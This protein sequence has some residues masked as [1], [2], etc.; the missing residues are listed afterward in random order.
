M[1]KESEAIVLRSYPLREADLLVTFFTRAEGKLKGVARSAM[2]SRRRFGGALEPL[3]AVRVYWEERERQELARI[4]SCEVLDSP[5][6]DAV[7]YGRAVALAHVAEV[8]DE[9][10]PDREANDPMFRLAGSVLQALKP[11]LVWAPVT[12]FDLWM[13]RLTGLLPH[14]GA[15][16]VCGADLDGEA[17]FFHPLMDGLMCG[18]DRRLASEE[19]S[20]ESRVLAAE[21]FRH[22]IA[23]FVESHG[24]KQCGADLRRFLVQRME[25]HVE[26]PLTTARM[27]EK[28]KS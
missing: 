15:C 19:L 6:A 20:A 28:L 16:I 8:L 7:S 10:L 13:V 3:T 12:Y 14:L 24:G 5:L 2:K 27:L 21:M 4:D 25:R 22:P 26:K 17:A 18:G 11:G 1:L 23:N 9:L